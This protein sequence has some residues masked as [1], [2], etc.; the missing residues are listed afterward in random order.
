MS[1]ELLG[2]N[3]KSS[4]IPEDERLYP[5]LKT[6]FDEQ[7]HSYV[8]KIFREFLDGHGV[9]MHEATMFINECT[10]FLLLAPNSKEF[11]TSDNP[12]CRFTNA[13]GKFEYIFPINPKIAC[14]VV[15]GGT[16]KAYLLQ[17]ISE[18]ELIYLN[19]KLKENCFKGYIL[20]EQNLSLYF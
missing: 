15:K 2:V 1:E 17:K 6:A 4:L 20:H 18:K 5:F 14:R 10:I 9:I 7:A 16:Q 12:V 11:I 3:L 19:N 8:L 13:E